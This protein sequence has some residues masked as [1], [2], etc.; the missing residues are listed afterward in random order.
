VRSAS[1][2]RI[3]PFEV[4]LVVVVVAAVVAMGVWFFCFSTGGIGPGTV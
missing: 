3:S 1:G 4:V 2:P